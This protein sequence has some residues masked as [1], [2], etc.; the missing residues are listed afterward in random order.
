MAYK[1]DLD[2]AK[3]RMDAWW[4]HEIIDRPAIGYYC[5]RSDVPLRGIWDLWYLAK[6]PD[7][8]DGALANF[9]DKAGALVFGGELI[10][11]F[12]PNYGP[13]VMASVLGAEAHFQTDTVWFSYPATLDNVVEVLESA[14]LDFDNPWYAR[15]LRI[16]ERAVE[17]AGTRY[18][19]DITDLGGVMDVIASFL[20][21]RD[22]FY[23]MRNKPGVI[24]AC[25][26]IVL[27]KMLKV[28]DTL[29]AKIGARCHGCGA[30]LQVWGRKTWYPIQCD[31][32]Y[33][34]SPAYFKRFVLPDITA[35]ARHMERAIYH[36]D[37]VNQLPYLDDLLSIP[38]LTGIQWVPGAGKPVLGSDEW[39]SVFKKIQA[40]GKNIVAMDVTPE[41]VARMYKELDHKGLYVLTIFLGQMIADFYLPEFMGGQGG[42]EDDDGDT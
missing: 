31:F 29:Q 23:A 5:P 12:F 14:K 32:A 6:D 19:V 17:R 35:Q 20:K 8:I 10:P 24:D 4:D 9:E 25:R 2:A 34:L 36:L 21:P 33:M 28:Y 22:I 11:N 38:E 30:W 1:E 18:Q 15:L 13:G 7:N 3:Q 40:A 42:V 16:T 39:M 37:G 26:A 27:E 41:Y